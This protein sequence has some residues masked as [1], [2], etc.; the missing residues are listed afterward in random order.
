MTDARLAMPGDPDLDCHLFGLRLRE[1]V[2]I[3]GDDY[4]VEVTIDYD[5]SEAGGFWTDASTGQRVVPDRVTRTYCT[6]GLKMQPGY[7]YLLDDMIGRLEAWQRDKAVI[8][9]TAAPGKWTLL[10]CPGHP[11]GSQVVYPRGDFGGDGEA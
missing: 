1:I 2:T 4:D 11:A 8:A 7:E 3:P 5:V 6:F 9:M 10:H